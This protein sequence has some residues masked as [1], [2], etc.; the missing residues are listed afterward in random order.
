MPK[1]WTAS[2][3]AHRR[4]V[5]DAIIDSAAALVAEGGLRSVTM[6]R[7]AERTGI[8]R[9]TL[10]RYFSDVESILLAWHER[11]IAGHLEHLTR[12]KDQPGGAG[13]RLKAVLHAYALI[14]RETRGHHDTDLVAFLH[15][16]EQVARARHRL[17]DLV[18]DLIA[19]GAEA[20]ELRDDVPPEE[21]TAYCLN[22]LAAAGGLA[23]QDAVQRLVRVTWAGLLP[24]AQSG[25]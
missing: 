6:S 8:G 9:A 4:E 15:H 3:E 24:P 13:E 14:A 2:I 10:Y 19:A 16:D 18:R 20:G 5:R 21:L 1:L 25:Q 23:S 17:H 22:A 12:L 11:Q 7:I